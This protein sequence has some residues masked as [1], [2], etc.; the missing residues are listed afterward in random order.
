VGNHTNLL[1]V[2]EYS[3]IV[4]YKKKNSERYSEKKIFKKK[5]CFASFFPH[6]VLWF[7][8]RELA[9]D[10][11]FRPR[12]HHIVVVLLIYMENIFLSYKCRDTIFFKRRLALSEH[13]LIINSSY[14]LTVRHRMHESERPERLRYRGMRVNL[15][16]NV[17]S[18]MYMWAYTHGIWSKIDGYIISLFLS[19][20]LSTK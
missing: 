16:E 3:R 4:V 15:I 6:E 1:S 17:D 8:S 20:E 7:F 18:F 5:N 9:R 19:L 13:F 11:H 10:I 2:L 12:R 14:E